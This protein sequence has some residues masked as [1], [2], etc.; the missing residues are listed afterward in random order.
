MSFLDFIIKTNFDIF[1]LFL[2]IILI[3]YFY[4][5][6]HKTNIEYFLLISS[7]IGVIIDGKTVYDNI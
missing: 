4:S 2:F 6:E 5:I 7:I 3:L 1:G